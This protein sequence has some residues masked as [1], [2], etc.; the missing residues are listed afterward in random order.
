MCSKSSRLFVA[1]QYGYRLTWTPAR[2]QMLAWLTQL[3]SESHTADGL[4]V[5]AR[6]FAPRKL[7]PV[8]DMVCSETTRASLLPRGP[9]RT[10]RAAETKGASPE[11]GKYS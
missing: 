3:G 10:F 6:N 2:P 5:S 7:A 4:R 8:P 9:K 1:S 11:M